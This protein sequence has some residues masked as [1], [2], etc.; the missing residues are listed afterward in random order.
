MES[1]MRR[2]SQV[3]FGGRRRGNHRLKSRHWRLA[4]DP[5]AT[6][7]RSMASQ[8]P[9]TTRTATGSSSRANAARSAVGQPGLLRPGTSALARATV[10]R[11][12]RPVAAIAA[13]AA[14]APAFSSP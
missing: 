6:V 3:R 14:I 2:N 11:P 8:S 12:A 13:V 4:A 10:E 9:S 1:R 7:R 5:T